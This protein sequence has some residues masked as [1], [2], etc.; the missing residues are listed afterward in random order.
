VVVFAKGFYKP[1]KLKFSINIQPEDRR[2]DEDIP[3]LRTSIR[4]GCE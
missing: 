2:V 3:V 4:E 1:K